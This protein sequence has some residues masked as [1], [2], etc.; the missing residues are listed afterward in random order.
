ML[1]VIRNISNMANIYFIRQKEP[2]GLGDTIRC[3]RSFIGMSYLPF[4]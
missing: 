1:N 4:Y 3:G 2:K